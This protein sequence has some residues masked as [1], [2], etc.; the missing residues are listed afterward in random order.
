MIE[1][2]L[3]SPSFEGE[4]TFKYDLKGFLKAYENNAHLSD[5]QVI[6][7]LTNLPKTLTDI[8]EMRKKKMTGTIKQ[9]YKEITFEMFWNAYGYKEDKQDAEKIWGKLTA[10]ERQEAYDYIPRY[11]KK[12]ALSGLAKKYPKTYLR[13]KPWI[14]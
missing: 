10:R 11:N 8:D 9:V 13:G 1:F 6:W 4:V 7:L 3:N 12:I 14:S 5:D 2:V